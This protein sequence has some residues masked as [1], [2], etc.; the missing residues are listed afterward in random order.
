[1]VSPTANHE[2][3][4]Q[5]AFKFPVKLD[6]LKASTLQINDRQ[7]GSVQSED[8]PPQ[9][10]L[11]LS[12]K[13]VDSK[14]VDTVDRFSTV[15]ASASSDQLKRFAL[16]PIQVAVRAPNTIIDP[17]T[18]AL[19]PIRITKKTSQP[20]D[21]S[22]TKPAS[23]VTTDNQVASKKVVQ[24]PYRETGLAAATVSV[25]VEGPD[26]LKVNQAG[27]YYIAIVNSSSEPTSVPSIR[28]QIP[29]FAEMLVIERQAQIDDVERT[30]TWNIPELGP[31]QQERIR[32]R[33]KVVAAGKVDL[34]VTV[35]QDKRESQT[36]SRTTDVK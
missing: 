24:K 19:Q 3:K 33:L 2:I 18:L 7:N 35:S 25:F 5:A 6:E 11:P 21:I 31:G 10:P 20:R 32:F 26:S 12:S 16:M 36:I 17:T 30:L 28:L 4:P 27:D 15:Q 22:A 34:P 9:Q 1:M 13:P 23:N 29:D 14:P 8:S